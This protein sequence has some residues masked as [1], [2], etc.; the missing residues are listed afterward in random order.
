MPA[1]IAVMRAVIDEAS[2]MAMP[3]TALIM[4]SVETISLCRRRQPG[5]DRLL[6]LLATLQHLRDRHQ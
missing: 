2:Q 3:I 5:G 1:M 6:A 4:I